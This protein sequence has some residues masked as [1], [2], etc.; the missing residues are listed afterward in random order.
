MRDDGRGP[1]E[2]EAG[3]IK[4][5][6]RTLGLV[7]GQ[8]GDEDAGSGARWATFGG[9]ERRRHKLLGTLREPEDLA[10]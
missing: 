2:H 9:D 6:M 3:M 4:K 7:T 10:G 8:V 1:W 5:A